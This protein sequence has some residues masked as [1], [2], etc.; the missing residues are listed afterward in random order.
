MVVIWCMPSQCGKH[1]AKAI[2]TLQST[3]M[4]H[5][6]LSPCEHEESEAQ[7]LALAGSYGK[8]VSEL[9]P[10]SKTDWLQKLCS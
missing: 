3:S 6:L 7:R 4:R 2:I 8:Y 9:E 5:V 10:I 1:G